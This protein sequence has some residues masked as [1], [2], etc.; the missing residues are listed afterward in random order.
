MRAKRRICNVCKRKYK[1]EETVC[2]MCHCAQHTLSVCEWK[3]VMGLNDLFSDFCTCTISLTKDGIVVL[4]RRLSTIIN[5]IWDWI[6][7][8]L[9]YALAFNEP[10]SNIKSINNL[11]R[12]R[13][14]FIG[15]LKITVI[16]MYDGNQY[17]FLRFKDDKLKL[18]E[19]YSKVKVNH[20]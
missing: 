15:T 6:F 19:E 11:E 4:K 17:S 16:E 18:L 12:N 13:R 20:I 9:N 8:D 1:E 10:Y 14:R 7:H 2:P 5:I 3:G